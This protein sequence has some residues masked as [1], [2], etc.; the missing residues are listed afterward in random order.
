MP[1]FQ[2]LRHHN[3]TTEWTMISSCKVKYCLSVKRDG[4]FNMSSSF[5]ADTVNIP[6]DLEDVTT[7]PPQPNIY[8]SQVDTTFN[9]YTRAGRF[10]MSCNRYTTVL[11]VSTADSLYILQSQKAID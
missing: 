8:L 1:I 2:Y 11:F 10:Q 4:G 3:M 5:W 7:C 6:V 9:C